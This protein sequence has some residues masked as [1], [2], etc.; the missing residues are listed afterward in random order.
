[1]GCEVDVFSTSHDKDEMVKKYG[2]DKVYC[3]KDGEH[4]D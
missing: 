3:T 1:M 2:G 4:K